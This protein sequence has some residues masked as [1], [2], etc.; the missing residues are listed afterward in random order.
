MD[1]TSVAPNQLEPAKQIVDR[2]AAMYAACQSYMDEGEVNTIFI[3]NKGRRIV[4]KPFCTA[5]VRPSNFRFEFR[6]RHSE[7]EEWQRYMVWT[8][9]ISVKTWWTVR[10][11]VE[12]K[13][14]LSRAI[15]GATGVSSGSAHNIPKLLMPDEITGSALSSVVEW[16]L[17]REEDVG[18]ITAY[19]I[20]GRRHGDRLTTFWV[21]K[22][23][24]LI[25][26]IFSQREHADFETETTTTYRPQINAPIPPERL[27]FD[28][29]E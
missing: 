3:Q 22:R 23:T 27:T 19:V 9:G 2:M 12:I 6:D 20:E 28:V 15:A 26:K 7:E 25:L 18:S 8:D 24:L 13:P 14:S 1:Q 16:K 10:P 4:T 17:L 11:G 5:F 29:P 21:D